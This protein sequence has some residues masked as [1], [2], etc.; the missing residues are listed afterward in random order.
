MRT[1]LAPSAERRLLKAVDAGLEPALVRERF[2]LTEGQYTAIVYRLRKERREAM[3]A[4]PETAHQ[5][6]PS[7]QQ[8]S[9]S[10]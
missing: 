2:G 10:G 6:D 7:Q 5:S 3:S 8:D 9:A 1:T 4:R